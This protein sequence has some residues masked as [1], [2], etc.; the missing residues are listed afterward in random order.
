[1]QE[2]KES[3]LVK[4]DD[5][6]AEIQ[7][8]EELKNYLEEEE[9]EM[10]IQLKEQYEP[11]IG[12]IYNEVAEKDPLQLEALEKVLLETAFEGLYLPRILGYSV[13]RGEVNS[14]FKYIRPQD[15]F[16][17]V[18]LA[19]CNS[20]NFD[21]L[22][23]R[24]GQSIQMGFALSSDIW[25]T[26]LINSIENKRV[27][28]FLQ[29]QKL[30]RFRYE[31]ER[32]AGYKRYQ[33]Q[34][35]NDNFYTAYFPDTLS[36]LKV[37]Y[38]PVKNFILYRVGQKWDNSS[39]VP[40]IKK[41]IGNEEFKG[42]H[43]HLEIATLYGMFFDFEEED[44]AHLSK[45]LN[46][47][48]K[49][50]EDFPEIF[51]EYLLKLHYRKDISITPQADL[52]FSS[53]LDKSIKDDLTKYYNLMDIV[54]TE[55]YMKEEAQ[56]AV[57]AFY[58]QYEGLSTINECVRQTIYGYFHRFISNLEETDYPEFFEISKLFPA[59][60]AIFANQQFN[61]QLKELCL[62]YVRRLLKKYTDKRGKD[63]Q[64]IK[65]FVSTTFQDLGFLKEK[66]IVEMF[67]T[68]RKRKKKES[69]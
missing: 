50:M 49:S 46:E 18:L 17:D 33:R 40:E 54:H 8:S 20:A 51:F 24:I 25:V 35:R 37:Y 44:K 42:Q 38:S 23:K 28:Y 57:K 13:L 6:A 63:Y 55:G 65:K 14:Q 62:T 53:M 22:R 67:K 34:F 69:S 32:R 15:H 29:S 12:L 4:L 43:E 3:Y 19:I 68:R 27:R 39:I 36:G 2:L 66:Q 31:D 58:V 52:Q 45:H 9:E 64:D 59:Y 48:R 21:I 5:L 41:L 16:K 61:Q 10:Y 60:M 1:M 26:N 11:R 56:D 30:D 7:E 47:V